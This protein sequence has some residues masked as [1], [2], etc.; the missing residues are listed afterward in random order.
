[1]AKQKNVIQVLIE[2]FIEKDYI[3]LNNN[4]PCIF[5]NRKLFNDI[6]FMNENR[7]VGGIQ[8]EIAIIGAGISGITAAAELHSLAHD[9]TL[10]EANDSIGGHVKT[11]HAPFPV[12]LGV[13]M[14]DPIY[15]HPQMGEKIRELG[16]KTQEIP[17][18][19]AFENQKNQLEWTT[20][21][22]F[23]GA[24]R[25]YSIVLSAIGTNLLNGSARRHARFLMEVKHFLTQMSIICNDE[26]WR[27]KSVQEFIDQESFSEDFLENWLLPQLMCWWGATREHALKCSIQVI[28]ESMYLVSIAPQYIFEGGWDE[29]TNGIAA[30]ILD[31]IRTGARVKSVTRMKNR[32]N[33]EVNGEIESFDQVV[34]ATP[35]NIICEILQNISSEEK[36]IHQR[37]ETI[38]TTVYLHQDSRWLPRHRKEDVV[39]LVQ[40]ER[41]SFCTLNF[42]TLL[43]E[44]PLLLV[45]WGDELKA[46]P[47]KVITEADWLRTLPTVD[48]T[49]ACHDIDTIQGKSGT[50]YCGAHVHA[51]NEDQI[52]SLWHENAYRSGIRIAE[53]M[54][55]KDVKND[56]RSGLSSIR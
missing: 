36:Q 14:H 16:L 2:S 38:T 43:P 32:I 50:W 15:I 49:Q 1:M 27:G 23:S 11:E 21:S 40:D 18:T 54:I 55:Q 48:Y 5:N 13:F 7:Y 31:R 46:T 47:E 56:E 30:P 28:M 51:L 42:G 33:V 37:F 3:R 4:F 29:F 26:Q 17:L 12:E 24:L 39:N 8:L 10:F 35:P 25:D 53:K 34:F 9:V 20:Q 19:F 44:N 6:L 52:P 41:G 45:T 22:R